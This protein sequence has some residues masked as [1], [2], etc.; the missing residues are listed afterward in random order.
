MLFCTSH[1]LMAF[2]HPQFFLGFFFFAGEIAE[3]LVGVVLKPLSTIR[4]NY[5][6]ISQHVC[7]KFEVSGFL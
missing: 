1:A 2:G 4:G 7:E 5:L 3:S 6:S